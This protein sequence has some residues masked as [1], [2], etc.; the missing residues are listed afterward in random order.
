MSALQIAI[1]IL[2]ISIAGAAVFTYSLWREVKSGKLECDGD[3]SE[4]TGSFD[5]LAT[6]KIGQTHE[7]DSKAPEIN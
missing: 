5:C 6:K 3:G 4:L 7:R 2:L 1:S